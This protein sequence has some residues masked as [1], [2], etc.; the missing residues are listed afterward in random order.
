MRVF[1][2]QLLCAVFRQK[3]TFYAQFTTVLPPVGLPSTDWTHAT[4][5][6]VFVYAFSTCLIARTPLALV[7]GQNAGASETQS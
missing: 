6:M 2:P 3:R 7:Q 4:K 5:G 1:A